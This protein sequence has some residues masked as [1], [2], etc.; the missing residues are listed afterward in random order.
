VA[1]EC[2]DSWMFIEENREVLIPQGGP[3]DSLSL[4]KDVETH[5]VSML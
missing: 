2:V 3:Y 1:R 4:R 5:R